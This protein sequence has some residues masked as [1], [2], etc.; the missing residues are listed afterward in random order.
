MVTVGWPAGPAY[1]SRYTHR[2]AIANSR[3]VAVDERGV[4]FNGKD[5]RAKGRTRYKAMTL[6]TDEFIRRF[7][8]HVLP[9]GFHRIRHYG[10]FTNAGR[11]N[12][13]ASV[14]EVLTQNALDDAPVALAHE[15]DHTDSHN[16]GEL[17]QVTCRFTHT[18]RC[19]CIPIPI[20]R[21]FTLTTLLH[22][23]VSSLKAYQTPAR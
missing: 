9:S 5:Y 6:A 16:L 1:L 4:T 17:I 18:W 14:R 11:Q 8:L 23:A 22:P 19:I 21:R 13:L 7:L 12:D 3:L 2:V 15:V 20:D 10:L